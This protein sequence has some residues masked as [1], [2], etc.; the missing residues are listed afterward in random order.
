MGVST[1]PVKSSCVTYEAQT[2]VLGL[3]RTANIAVSIRGECLSL[4]VTCAYDIEGGLLQDGMGARRR[5]CNYR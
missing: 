2:E 5:R 4:A 1:V 3:Q